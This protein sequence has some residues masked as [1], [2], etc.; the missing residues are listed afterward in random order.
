MVTQTQN[1]FKSNRTTKSKCRSLRRMVCSL[2]L[3]A[4]FLT[5]AGKALATDFTGLVLYNSLSNP[6]EVGAGG[7]LHGLAFASGSLPADGTSYSAINRAIVFVA[8]GNSATT[9]TVGLSDGA[10]KSAPITVPANTTVAISVEDAGGDAPAGWVE[11]TGF[12]VYAGA[13]GGLTIL[14]GSSA[15]KTVYATQHGNNVY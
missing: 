6:V 14:P 7:Q 12:V 2:T 15:T 10:I 8:G 13:G 3:M 5:F 1:L 4:G 9:C 11:T